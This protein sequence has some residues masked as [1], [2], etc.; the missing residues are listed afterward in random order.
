MDI[1]ISTIQIEAQAILGIRSSAKMQDLPDI[2]GA[3]F[4][5]IFG[6]VIQNGQQPAGMP[7]SRYHSMDGE[8]VDLECGIP[9]NAPLDGTDRIKPGSLPGGRVATV[10]HVGPYEGLPQTWSALFEWIGAEGLKPADAPWE[11]YLTDPGAE[12]DSSKWRTQIFFP[13]E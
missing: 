11:V 5:E 3:H 7:L 6:Y 12:P 2:L 9:I 10:T 4:G 1:E 8:S 13:V